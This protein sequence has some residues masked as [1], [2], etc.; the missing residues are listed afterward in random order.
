MCGTV[1]V[2]R[3]IHQ[4]DQAILSNPSIY[5]AHPRDPAE[6]LQGLPEFKGLNIPKSKDGKINLLLFRTDYPGVTNGGDT[7]NPG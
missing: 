6:N 7:V 2:D 5:A 3:P 1:N 4:D